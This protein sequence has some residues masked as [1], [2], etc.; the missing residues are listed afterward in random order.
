MEL[1]NSEIFQIST[2]ILAHRCWLRGVGF[3]CNQKALMGL[4][5]HFFLSIT[6]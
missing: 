4:Y 2:L 3:P 1:P 5:F 6:P